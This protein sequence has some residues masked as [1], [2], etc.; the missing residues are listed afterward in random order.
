[1]CPQAIADPDEIE[2]FA[3]ELNRFNNDLEQMSKRLT[4][5]MGQL[6]GSWRDKEFAKFE[7][8]FNQTM[9]N[10]RSFVNVSKKQVSYLKR[11]ARTLRDYLN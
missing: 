2:R 1:M 9:R 8:Q 5:K 11:K 3:N 7:Q 6:S 4:G 10:I